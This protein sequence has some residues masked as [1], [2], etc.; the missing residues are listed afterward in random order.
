MTNNLLLSLVRGPQALTAEEEGRG[1]RSVQHR[2][3]CS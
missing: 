2:S 3:S 1:R